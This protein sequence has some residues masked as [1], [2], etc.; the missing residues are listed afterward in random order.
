MSW[1]QYGQSNGRCPECKGP[2]KAS[3]PRELPIT[4]DWWET[5]GESVFRQHRCQDCQMMWVSVHMLMTP[6]EMVE[7]EMWPS[8]TSRQTPW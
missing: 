1:Y 5:V 3:K 2:L 8:D 7:K 4:T 6:E